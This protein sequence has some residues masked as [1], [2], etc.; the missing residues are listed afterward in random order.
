MPD[1]D[2]KQPA[3]AVEE[4]TLPISTF[5]NSLRQWQARWK[6]RQAAASTEPGVPQ[7]NQGQDEKGSCE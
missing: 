5:K 1:T 3:A 2:R 6:A 4:Q 7:Q